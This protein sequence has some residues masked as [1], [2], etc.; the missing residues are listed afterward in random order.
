MQS[1]A[2]RAATTSLVQFLTHLPGDHRPVDETSHHSFGDSLLHTTAPPSPTNTEGEGFSGDSIPEVYRK[3]IELLRTEVLKTAET[4]AAA[5]TVLNFSGFVIVRVGN[6][7]H[8]DLSFLAGFEHALLHS[9]WVADIRI[10]FDCAGVDFVVRLAQP[11]LVS[12]RGPR[13]RKRKHHTA[14]AVTVVDFQND[15]PAAECSEEDLNI[16]RNIHKVC[17]LVLKTNDSTYNHLDPIVRTTLRE[18]NN[19]F[20]LEVRQLSNISVQQICL[21]P[22]VAPY[23]I[24]K[25]TANFLLRC[26]LFTTRLNSQPLQMAWTKAPTLQL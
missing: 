16:L 7:T 4:Q 19:G 14:C 24:E 2:K 13:N 10:N 12:P 23:H 5:F 1:A 8:V 9:C 26:L 6:L 11:V 22:K 17:A 18:A 20:N 15:Y 25:V 21:V 3:G